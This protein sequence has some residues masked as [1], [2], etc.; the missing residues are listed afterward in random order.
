M[1]KTLLLAAALLTLGLSPVFAQPGGLHGGPNFGGAMDRVF[2]ANQ[3]F[4]AKMDF[5][6][7]Q[8]DS[9]AV[10]MPGKMSFDNGKS[11]FEINMSEVQGAK[12]PPSAAEQLKA[13]GMDTIIAI[14]RPDLKLGYVVYPGLTS[15]AATP[16]HD[17]ADTATPGDYKV[18]TKD[19]GKET[20]DGH[21]CAKR[22]VT[23]TGKDAIQHEYTVWCA[24]DLKDFPVKLV[25]TE[26]GSTVTMQFKEVSLAKP[27]ATLFDPPTGYTKYDDAETMMRTEMMKRMAGGMGTPPEQK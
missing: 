15:Y 7:S 5:Q 24:A 1:K 23:V 20:V 9:N 25:T 13:M 22:T 2:G 3:T 19:T 12:M 27:A 21:D 18:E 6:T 11:R 14:S 17:P 10:V 4:S 8:G 26:S 16:T